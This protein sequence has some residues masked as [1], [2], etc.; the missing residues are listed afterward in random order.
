MKQKLATFTGEKRGESIK[1]ITKE[2]N[3]KNLEEKIKVNNNKEEDIK[4]R[5]PEETT[6]KMEKSPEKSTK[7]QL[8][9][10]NEKVCQEIDLD[11][12]KQNLDWR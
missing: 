6:G 3:Q 7:D 1:K 12:V 10:R 11:G 9:M 2:N 4:D 8:M 5:Y